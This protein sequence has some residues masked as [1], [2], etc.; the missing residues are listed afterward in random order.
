MME[1]RGG[2]MNY[3]RK[4]FALL[5]TIAITT[6]VVMACKT[7]YTGAKVINIVR[8]PEPADY[9]T[10]RNITEF[11]SEKS[12]NFEF[13]VRSVD[14]SSDDLTGRMDDLLYT[15]YDSKTKWPEKLPEGFN[16]V[17]VME[18]YKNPGLN[19]RKLHAQG[20]TGKGVGIAIIDQTLLVDHIE[21]KDNIK[22]YEENEEA[23]KMNSQ[24]HGPAVASIAVGETV[25]VAPEA[26]LYYIAGDFGTYQNNNFEYDLSLLAK[27]IDRIMEI[28]EDLPDSN[29]IRVI[30]IS[31]GWDE[32]YKGY[33]EITKAINRAK[34]AGIFVVSSSLEEVYGYM[35]HG[36]GKYP[37]SDA[38]NF[39]SY[40]PGSWWEENAEEIFKH[41]LW[42]DTPILLIPM[43]F[44]CTAAPNGVN[45]Y[46]VYASGGWSWSIPYIAGVYALACQA[47]PDI[48]YGEFWTIALETGKS[49][50][51][52]GH[53]GKEYIM[54]KIINPEGIIDS[55]K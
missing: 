21:Y 52:K 1:Y 36:L 29:K 26:D 22:L 44:R 16:P 19:L 37:L 48:T 35:F 46:V 39:E 51:I 50:M 10:I 42:G 31:L 30:S 12:E 25:G 11:P 43:D 41:K 20:I 32:S 49:V 27:N 17:E 23:G 38:D 33:D 34:E 9:T 53:D 54:E 3:K 45:D 40:K 2:I 13:D 15:T 7:E 18:I 4:Y 8:H 6:S 5:M 55:L 28:N 47:D 14:L 24:M